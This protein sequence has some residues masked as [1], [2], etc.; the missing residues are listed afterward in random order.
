MKSVCDFIQSH[1]CNI[2]KIRLMTKL[3]RLHVSPYLLIDKAFMQRNN[4]ILYYYYYY[5]YNYY[6]CYYRNIS[7]AYLKHYYLG[8]IKLHRPIHPSTFILSHTHPS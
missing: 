4:T 8:A 3:D 6:Y 1:G 7:K 2:H 5:Y